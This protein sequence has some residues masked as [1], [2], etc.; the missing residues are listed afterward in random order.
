MNTP[1]GRSHSLIRVHL[2]Q[3]LDESQFLG[4]GNAFI[5]TH[6]IED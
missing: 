2:A 1:R 3:K 6:L 5:S 4:D